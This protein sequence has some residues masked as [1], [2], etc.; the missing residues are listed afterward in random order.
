MFLPFLIIN[1]ECDWWQKFYAIIT[2]LLISPK[3]Y[4]FWWQSHILHRMTWGQ[5]TA[6]KRYQREIIIIIVLGTT[7]YWKWKAMAIVIRI[8]LVICHVRG[9]IS[10][11]W[12]LN[13][14]IAFFLFFVVI[15]IKSSRQSITKGVYSWLQFWTTIIVILSWFC[16]LCVIM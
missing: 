8:W 1:D 10:R 11:W 2:R 5:C 12:K 16:N 3:P 15:H 4:L 13:I 9:I 14:G 6:M 7:I